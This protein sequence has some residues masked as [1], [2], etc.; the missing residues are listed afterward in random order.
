MRLM[1][2]ARWIGVRGDPCGTLSVSEPGALAADVWFHHV[3]CLNRRACESCRGSLPS[4]ERAEYLGAMASETE[5]PPRS[6]AATW[7]RVA[8]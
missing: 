3:A 4:A 6:R 2:Y 5:S 7:V 1:A 8:R